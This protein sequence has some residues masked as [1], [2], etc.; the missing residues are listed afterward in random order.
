MASR[1]P[2]YRNALHVAGLIAAVA[3]VV[4]GVQE[5]RTG[6][7]WAMIAVAVVMVLVIVL[8]RWVYRD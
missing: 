8:R 6:N 1:G 7:G 5:F 3:L 2:T 4:K